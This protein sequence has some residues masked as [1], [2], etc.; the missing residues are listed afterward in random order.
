MQSTFDAA[1]LAGDFGTVAEI[2]EKHKV[3]LLQLKP[4]GGYKT[5]IDASGTNANYDLFVIL[6]DKI[7]AEKNVSQDIMTRTME[8]IAEKMEQFGFCG[9]SSRHNRPVMAFFGKTGEDREE[10]AEV[11]RKCKS[12]FKIYTLIAIAY[13]NVSTDRVVLWYDTLQDPDLLDVYLVY[14][15]REARALQNAFLDAGNNGWA[16]YVENRYL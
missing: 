7:L 8:V 2:L 9:L 16:D 1:V 13:G 6:Y 5:L 10:L 15:P 12:K 14:F 11:I 4:Y 3:D